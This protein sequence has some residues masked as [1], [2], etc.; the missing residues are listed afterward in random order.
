[1]QTI[2]SLVRNRI[3]I[4]F[5][6]LFLDYFLV[7]RTKDSLSDLANSI[8]TILEE[9][10]HHED[11]QKILEKGVSLA[12]KM[13]STGAN[14]EDKIKFSQ[15]REKLFAQ[16]PIPVTQKQTHL[17]DIQAQIEEMVDTMKNCC[18]NGLDDCIVKECY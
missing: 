6:S 5:S 9:V 7:W 8:I 10:L 3:L 2:F 15:L 16:I 17:T 1:M 14:E 13:Q 11:D 4:I 18:E 12:E